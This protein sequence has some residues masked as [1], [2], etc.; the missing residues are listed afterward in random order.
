[1]WDVANKLTVFKIAMND[2]LTSA[3]LTMEQPIGAGEQLTR[4]WRHE[5]SLDIGVLDCMQ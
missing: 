2:H 1:M 4:Q 5:V 3:T